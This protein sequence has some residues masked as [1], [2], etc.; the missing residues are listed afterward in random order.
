MNKSIV[1]HFKK[2][3]PILARLAEKVGPLNLQHRRTNKALDSENFYF[4]SLTSS[5]IGQQLSGK[6]ADVIFKRF[7]ELFH[8]E[9]ITPEYVLKLDKEIIRKIGISYSKVSYLKDLASKFKEDEIKYSKLDKLSDKEVT[10]ELIKIKGIGPW[11][12]EMFLMFTLGREDIFSHGDLGLRR[13][14][15]N[16]YQIENPTREQVESI[17]IKWSPYRSYAS[18][19]LWKSLDIKY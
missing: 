16:I 7:K 18:L 12:A 14:I 6:V 11:T 13:A 5:I 19:V 15:E 9:K 3:D 4:A 8:K 2:V 10:E 17:S 1:A